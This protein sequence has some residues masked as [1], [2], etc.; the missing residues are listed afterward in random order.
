VAA[1][2][3]VRACLLSTHV[4]PVTASLG[5]AGVVLLCLVV[6]RG[7]DDLLGASMLLLG[8]A[9]VLGLLVGRHV[10]DEG[11]PIVGAAMLLACE[12]AAW[13]LDE[14]VPVR[15]DPGLRARRAG[16]IAALVAGGVAAAAAVLAV[17]STAVGSGIGWTLLGALAVV[18]TI[19]IAARSAVAR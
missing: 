5:G 7:L 6:V 3:L 19:G 18:A 15:A 2:V 11:A 17:S 12:L 14:R 4:A 9:Y 1:A 10:L 16:A 13:S 8:C